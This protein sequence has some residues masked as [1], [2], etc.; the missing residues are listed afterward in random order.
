MCERVHVRALRGG[1]A[2]AAGARNPCGDPRRLCGQRFR[3]PRSAMGPRNT[4][5]ARP[6]PL[7][8]R[9][10]K[11][12]SSSP[13]PAGTDASA[14]AD[15]QPGKRARCGQSRPSP[16]S[17][18]SPE[19]RGAGGD[20]SGRPAGP[21]AR[22]LGPELLARALARH[23]LPASDS[24]LAGRLGGTLPREAGGMGPRFHLQ[25]LLSGN[26]LA[27]ASP[28]QQLPNTCSFPPRFILLSTA[29]S[30]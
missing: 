28:S 22:P 24:G 14:A 23:R 5:P 10:R 8:G 20:S 30:S 1:L 19:G 11:T 25:P 13:A 17:G 4:R 7:C 6:P 3:S 16:R 9:R 26:G 2:G 29:S 15:H 21:S 18:C 12:R 27:S